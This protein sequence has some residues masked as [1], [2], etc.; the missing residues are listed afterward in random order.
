MNSREHKQERLRN[1]IQ[2]VIFWHQFIA[3]T[4]MKV[5]IYKN[6]YFYITVLN[7]SVIKVPTM[8]AVRMIKLSG[9][10]SEDETHFA[11]NYFGRMT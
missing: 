11:I 5:E 1:N 3:Y 2:S 7:T 4:K 8:H 6:T 9:R 10:L